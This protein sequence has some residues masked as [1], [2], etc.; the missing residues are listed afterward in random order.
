MGDTTATVTGLYLA[1]D[2]TP[3]TGT[4]YMSPCVRAGNGQTSRIVTEK[5]VWA[6]LDANGAV[7]FD[8]IPSDD[9][10]W[11]TTGEVVYLVEE[12]LHQLEHRAYYV[13]VPSTGLDLAS[14]A[15]TDECTVAYAPVPGPSG[16]AGPASGALFFEWRGDQ[17]ADPGAGGLAIAGRGSSPRTF[18]VSKVDADGYARSFAILLPGD[19]IAITDDPAAPPITGFARYVVTAD[20]IDRGGWVEIAANRTDTA[21]SQADPSIGTRLRAIGTFAGGAA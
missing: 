1:A 21:G 5:R 4:V 17:V 7:S 14:A 20:V 11:H 2:N 3:A 10:D 13:G 8:V 16:R 18:A 9:P 19:T 6:D 15:Q 12:R